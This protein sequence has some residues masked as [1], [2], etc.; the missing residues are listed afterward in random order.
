MS[1][2]RVVWNGDSISYGA[3]LEDRFR[4]F[5]YL[6]GEALGAEVHNYAIAGATAAKRE[7][8]YNRAFLSSSEWQKFLDSGKAV[9]GLKYLVKDNTFAARPYRI[10]R[11]EDYSWIPG[12]NGSIDCARTPLVDRMAEMERDADVV[13]IMI[14]TNDFYYNWVPFGTVGEG[15]LRVC[16]NLPSKLTFCGAMHRICR[17]ILDWYPHSL[18]TLLTPIKRHQSDGIGGGD[19]NCFYPEDRNRFGLTLNDYRKAIIEIANYY[20]IPII[21]LYGKSRLNP[22]IDKSIF[23]DKDGKYVHPNFEGHERM[24]KLVVGALKTLGL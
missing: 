21:D 20:S 24:A 5:P 10:Y 6:V 19:W 14:G 4:A 16:P 3:Q 22:G 1:K 18:I 8:S 15:F 7:G 23:A 17:H 9:P 12:G 2:I 11:Y 13:G